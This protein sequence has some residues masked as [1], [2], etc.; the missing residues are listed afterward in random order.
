L[1]SYFEK[2]GKIFIKNL[3][4]DTP[5]VYGYGFKVEEVESWKEFTEE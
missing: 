4:E 1:K 3:L 5:Q 2:V